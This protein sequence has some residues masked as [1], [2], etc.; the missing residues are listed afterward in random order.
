MGKKSK[1]HRKKV[2]KRNQ[3]I[4]DKN[5]QQQKSAMDFLMKMIQQ[6]KNKGLFDNPVQPLPNSENSESLNSFKNEIP[7]TENIIVNGPQI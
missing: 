1:E 6:E 4:A 2:A 3:K 5:K 7:V